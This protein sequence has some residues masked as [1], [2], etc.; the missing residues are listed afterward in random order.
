MNK[1]TTKD[2]LIRERNADGYGLH[3]HEVRQAMFWAGENEDPYSIPRLIDEAVL[4]LAG[5]LHFDA[6]TVFEFMNSKLGRW[7]G[8]EILGHSKYD[9]K[10]IELILEKY[11]KIF[12]KEIT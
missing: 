7:A 11:L 5:R 9:Q 1:L 2:L 10:A 4:M 3:G 12:L 8:D 6:D